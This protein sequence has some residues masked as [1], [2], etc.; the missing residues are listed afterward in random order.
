MSLTEK[1]WGGASKVYTFKYE[2][3]K[4]LVDPADPH[5]FSRNVDAF[6]AAVAVG[7]RLKV[8]ALS[9]GKGR[10]E[11][12]NMYSVDQDEVLWAVISALHPEASGTERF[13]KLMG[14]ADFGIERL[15]EEFKI[16]GNLQIAIDT[17]LNQS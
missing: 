10:E 11:L 17:I 15:E 8:T 2:T 16:F 7:I 14:Y 6:H 12:L 3:Y 4:R 9:E 1:V 13:E 5:K